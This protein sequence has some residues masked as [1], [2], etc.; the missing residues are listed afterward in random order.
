MEN[1]VDNSINF[2]HFE[3]TFSLLWWE[4]MEQYARFTKDPKRAK[5]FQLNLKA[6]RFS[7]LVT[8]VFRQFEVLGDQECTEQ[9]VK[10]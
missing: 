4:S 6:Y 2:E 10:D 5:N 1:Y 3:I 7:S 9:E 8:C